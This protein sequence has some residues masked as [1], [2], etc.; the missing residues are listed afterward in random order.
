MAGK[1]KNSGYPDELKTPEERSAYLQ[2]WADR[3]G[4]VLKDEEIQKNLA[5]ARI[6]KLL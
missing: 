2:R 5:L 4:I 3:H 1:V 6:Y